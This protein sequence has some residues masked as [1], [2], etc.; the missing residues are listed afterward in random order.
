MPSDSP[1]C[2]RHALPQIPK[3]GGGFTG[4]CRQCVTEDSKRKGIVR[5]AKP[6]PAEEVVS[7]VDYPD[8]HEFVKERAYLNCR[9]V[10]QEILYRLKAA[11]ASMQAARRS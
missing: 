8:L 5:K 3:K 4:R 6:N 2:T 7:F 11:M 9:T 1:L 10:S